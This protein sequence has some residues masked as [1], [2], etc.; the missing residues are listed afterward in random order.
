MSDERGE[1][2]G[3]VPGERWYTAAEVADIL[4]MSIY[5]VRDRRKDGTLKAKKITEAGQ[6]QYRFSDTAIAEFM[7]SRPDG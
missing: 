4:H 6:G 1:H 7:A 3:V 2:P 5:W